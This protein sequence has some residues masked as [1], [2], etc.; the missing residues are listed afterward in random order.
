MD[1]LEASLSD[2]QYR[3]WCEFFALEPWGSEVDF[4]RAGIIAATV[5]NAA[6]NRKPGSRPASPRDFMPKEDRS[7]DDGLDPRRIKAELL[8][9]FGSRV[10]GKG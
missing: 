7:R 6:P 3:E 10:K 2:A 4:F 5:A 9:G 1:A 8:A